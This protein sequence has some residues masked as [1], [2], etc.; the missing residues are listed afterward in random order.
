MGQPGC[1]AI[2]INE[3]VK[4]IR[5]HTFA[6]TLRIF[7]KIFSSKFPWYLPHNI[8]EYLRWKTRRA[9][10]SSS[11]PSFEKGV[12]SRVASKSSFPKFSISHQ[13]WCVACC[14]C[15]CVYVTVHPTTLVN[16]AFRLC[17]ARPFLPFFSRNSAAMMDRCYMCCRRH[18][19]NHSCVNH[20][21]AHRHE[22]TQS[23]K[24]ERP[25]RD[26]GVV[27]IY[28]LLP[29]PDARTLGVHRASG[30]LLGGVLH[31]HGFDVLTALPMLCASAPVPTPKERRGG[32]SWEKE[33]RV[34]KCTPAPWP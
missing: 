20:P 13:P 8:I 23:M 19:R 32:S 6:P 21:L 4:N 30:E 24:T 25:T 11:F 7:L 29:V 26:A 1:S 34:K 2:C 16:F 5:L 27:Q 18:G 17:A 28:I 9:P 14:V 15:G 22:T 12:V 31:C 3:Y 33:R 10:V